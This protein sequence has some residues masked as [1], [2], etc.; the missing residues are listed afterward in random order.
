MYKIE[1][2]EMMLLSELHALARNFTIPDFKELPKQELI[3]KIL[4]KQ[5]VMPQ[6]NRKPA[7]NDMQDENKP[8]R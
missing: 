3:Y 8:E 2:L 6:S 1:E 7:N 5:A 4:S